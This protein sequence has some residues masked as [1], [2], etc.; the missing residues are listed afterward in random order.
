MKTFRAKM[1]TSHISGFV[2]VGE[3]IMRSWLGIIVMPRA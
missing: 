2:P 1:Q 3:Q